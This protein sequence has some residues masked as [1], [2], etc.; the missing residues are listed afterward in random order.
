MIFVQPAYAVCPVCVLAAGS[1]L[2]IAEV[3]GVDDLIAALFIGAVITSAAFWMADK[4]KLVKL[5]QAEISWSVIFY[6][7]TVG[8]LY[9]QGKIGRP[10]CQL[11]GIDKVFLGLTLGTI[12]FIAG[13]IADRLLRTKNNSKGYF[14]F[15]KV[16][17]P[18]ALVVVTALF[19]QFTFCK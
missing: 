5:P 2:G 19:F 6:L 17:I 8:G 12:L 7:M 4:F 13:V 14:P 1:A 16:V 3:L 10:S 9:T 15:Q 18:L 11:W